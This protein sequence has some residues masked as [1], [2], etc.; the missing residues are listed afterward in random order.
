MWIV[1]K[2]REAIINWRT[3]GETAPGYTPDLLAEVM[4]QTPLY[5]EYKALVDGAVVSQLFEMNPSAG[6]LGAD[7][8]ELPTL[9]RRLGSAEHFMKGLL[10]VK[11]V[12]GYTVDQ[13]ECPKT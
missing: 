4:E 3:K 7:P 10:R 8:T 6:A 11:Q 12:L 13:R 1:R 9:I 2:Y 5:K